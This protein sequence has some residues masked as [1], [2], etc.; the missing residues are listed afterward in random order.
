MI[1]TEYKRQQ[2]CTSEMVK[3]CIN[4]TKNTACYLEKDLKFVCG[5]V[6]E[7]FPGWK[8]VSAPDVD[9]AGGGDHHTCGALRQL[10]GV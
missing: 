7:G 6:L 9:G 2:F 5:G 10:V 8:I 1:G 4:T 3:K